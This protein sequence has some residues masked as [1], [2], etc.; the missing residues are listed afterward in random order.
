M[1]RI[2]FYSLL[3]ILLLI[4]CTVTGIDGNRAFAGLEAESKGKELIK[5]F[6]GSP[7]YVDVKAGE[8]IDMDIQY[9]SENNF[10]GINLYGDYNS[11]YLHREAAQK[12][13]AASE[14]LGK[15]RPGWKLLLFDCLR[16]RRVQKILYEKVKGTP[17]Q[18]Y[19]ANPAKGSIHNYGFAVDLSIVDEKG[20]EIDMGTPFDA[21]TKLSRPSMEEKFLKEGKLTD[22]QLENRKILRS[23]MEKAGFIQ[24]PVEWWHFDALPKTE[25]KTKY[26]IIE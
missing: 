16:P 20:A 18:S 13:I 25:V 7:D 14:L 4:S 11:C 3:F 24:L 15:S 22:K 10:A 8:F 23:V 2:F 17:Q 21:F 5:Y 9:A 6:E 19:V 1:K 26:K 12:L